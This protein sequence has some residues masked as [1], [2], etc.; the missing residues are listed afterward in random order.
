MGGID[1]KALAKDKGAISEELKK[2][3]RMVR[4]GGYVPYTDHMVPPD[5]SFSNYKFFRLELKKILKMLKS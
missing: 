2:V 3:E 4:K 1:K 5:V